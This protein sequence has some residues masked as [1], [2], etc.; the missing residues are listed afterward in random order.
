MPT[1]MREFPRGC[2]PLKPVL[3]LTEKSQPASVGQ[4]AER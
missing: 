4:E 3:I 1:D 2:Y